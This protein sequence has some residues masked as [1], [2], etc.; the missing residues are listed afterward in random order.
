MRGH[1]SRAL[2]A[3]RGCPLSA[4][5]SNVDIVARVIAIVSAAIALASLVLTSYQWRH[6]GPELAAKVEKYV[7]K[8]RVGH[9]DEQWTFTIDVW[10]KGRMP[11]TVRDI[12][13]V[14]LRW[15]WHFSWWFNL[16]L[17]LIR[18]PDFAC[19]TS[20]HPVEGTFPSEVEGTF[21]KEIP[22]TGYLRARAVV[23]ADLFY[24]H[25]RWVQAL[26]VTGIGATS[27]QRPY[28]LR[29]MRACRVVCIAP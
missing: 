27:G 6:S 25:I 16:W 18:R 5:A 13:V 9:R 23:D 15:R 26:V 8:D 17:R 21:P 1:S 29:I 22:P 11:H 4:H 10:N 14:R 24:P 2:A 12:V 20:A 3:R 7:R 28:R 19:C